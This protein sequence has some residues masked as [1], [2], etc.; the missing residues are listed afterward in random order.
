[1]KK[2][3]KYAS[4]VLRHKWFVF[5][6]GCKLGIPVLAALHDNS[7]FR[8]SEWFPY[9]NF[10]YG[11]GPDAGITR[12][13][14]KTG[15]Y[16]PHDT[17]NAAFD[18]AWFLHQK[19]N[20]HHWQYWVQVRRDV[21]VCDKSPNPPSYGDERMRTERAPSDMV[22]AAL[23]GLLP[24]DDGGVKCVMCGEWVSL[25]RFNDQ[26]LAVVPMADRYRKEMLADWRGA[27]RAQGTP[28]TL[29]WYKA[30]GGKMLLHRETRA[31]IEEQLNFT[32]VDTPAEGQTAWSTR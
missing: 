30:N 14:D 10:F 8:P 6:V 18:W 17:G 29:A 7:K 32:A 26:T 12:H 23:L 5:L 24:R 31:W 20:K 3:L 16:K 11:T 19:R 9:V 22:R 25:E 13:R 15:Y 4:Y 21:H 27:G 2:H 28:D 1:M